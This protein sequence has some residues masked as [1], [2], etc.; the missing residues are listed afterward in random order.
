MR[1]SSD[2]L[3]E[4]RTRG[5]L[6]VRSVFTPDEVR[7]LQSVT[8]QFVEQS[9]HVSD[10]TDA[11]DLEPGHSFDQPRLRRLKA[12]H[13]RH[14]AYD[15][16]LRNDTLLGLLRQ[17]LGDGVRFQNTKL[18]M[19]SPEFGSPVEWHQDWAFYPHTNDDVLAVG[20]A[21]DDM[22]LENGCLMVVP[23][24]HT[25][26]VHDHHQDGHFVGAVN[27]AG[28]IDDAAP[29]ELAAGDI[30]IHHARLLHGS[31]PNTSTRP[32][33]FLLFEYAAADAWPLV[34]FTDWTEFN[35]RLLCGSPVATPRLE[36]V[37][38]RIPLP[39]HPRQGSIYEVQSALS[40]RAFG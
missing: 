22:M 38:V 31:A 33:R 32:R 10:H 26:P 9:R 13:R 14:R 34:N 6:A 18:N 35:S 17:L 16:A 12:P 5:Y 21:I 36:P 24:S 4:Y 30:S 23:G 20:I 37:P 29:I 1:L 28:L 40:H 15:R 2:Q 11:F 25:G 8:D 3:D 19:K 27:P 7:E 39:A